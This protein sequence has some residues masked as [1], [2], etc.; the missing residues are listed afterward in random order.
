M[1][2]ETSMIF[3]DHYKAPLA[4]GAYRFV[5]QQTVSLDGGDTHHYYRDQRFE[6]VAPR[7]VIEGSEIQARFP[8]PGGVADYRSILPHIV[9]RTRNL[10]WERSLW[11][12]KD[13]Q[14]QAP[15]LVLLV[16]SASDLTNGKAEVRTSTLADLKP[17]DANA[18]SRAESGATILLPRFIRTEDEQTPVRLLDLD[19]SVFLQICPRRL[20]LPSLAHVRKVDTGNKVPLEMAADGEFSVLVANRFPT[21]GANTVHLISLEGWQSLLDSP[22]TAPQGAR[23]RLVTL[24]SWNFV[25][26]KAGHD[27][28]GGLMRKLRGNAVRFGVQLR[29]P[30]D[31]PYVQQALSRGYVPLDYL[32][33]ESTAG[34]A[35]YRG[36]LAP[37]Q[38]APV[39]RPPYHRADAALIFDDQTAL[40][41]LSYATAWQLGRLLALSSPAFS[42]GLRLFVESCQNAAEVARQIKDFLEMHRNAFPDLATGNAP[43]NGS[44]KLAIA[45]E[46]VQWIARLVLL[47]PVPFHYLIPNPALLPSES[48]RFFHLDDN[49]VDALVDGALSIA[50]RHAADRGIASRGDLQSALSRIVYQY[51]LRLQGKTPEWNPNE[52]HME[53]PK[54]GLLLRS[55]IVSGWPGV[56]VTV[57]TSGTDDTLPKI[58][59]MDQIVDGV[60]FCL[61][62]DTIKKVTF[63]EPLEGLT[64][65]VASEG[66][67]RGRRSSTV[68]Q[69]RK[70]FMRAGSGEGVADIAGLRGQLE[71]QE[72]VRVGA[73][74]FAMQMLR[75]PEEQIIEWS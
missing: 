68:I 73:A 56:E 67:L 74:E 13:G 35:W 54:S 40:M 47:Y 38:R 66:T 42:K 49:W 31:N 65:G 34:Y 1:S 24:D 44:E 52:R 51:R 17:H 5:L 63:R 36:P 11:P 61:V 20:D 6:V 19:L 26:D 28:F 12:G 71:K 75:M 58:L 37:I 9:L 16:L 10:P 29:S 14:E 72:N 64:F 62:R 21:E 18:W 39:K 2:A 22:P 45:D 33:L 69:L 32:P 30:S 23:I 53:A 70:D 50:V 8:P 46:L 55:S 48:L 15:W 7:Y 27:T 4:A 59:R 41:D 25:N 3:Y 57:E 60:L 43:A